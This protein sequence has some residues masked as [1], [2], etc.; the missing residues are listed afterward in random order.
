MDKFGFNQLPVVSSRAGPTIPSDNVSYLVDTERGA[1]AHWIFDKGDADG[2]NSL[3][4]EHVLAPQG[5]LPSYDSNFLTLQ[6]TPK[7]NALLTPFSES[8]DE[9]ST[10]WCVMRQP[11]ATAG[12]QIAMG[13]LANSVTT[14]DGSSPWVASQNVQVNS[15]GA[16]NINALLSVPENEWVV[17]I[18]SRNYINGSGERIV[19][20]GGQAPNVSAGILPG[21]YRPS[22][23]NIALG[24]GYYNGAAVGAIQYAEFGMYLGEQLD[25][26]G[27]VALAARVRQRMADRGITLSFAP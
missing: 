21:P 19:S 10:M 15:M 5:N 4:G 25:V 8:T 26:Q 23:G 12:L 11:V 24:N 6:S 14:N 13:T 1:D 2:L 18:Y 16:G 27:H 17:M 22:G 20:I 9:I 3:I 7:G